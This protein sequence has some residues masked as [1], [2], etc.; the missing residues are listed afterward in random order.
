MLFY[1]ENTK[2]AA[3]SVLDHKGD[4]G[5]WTTS[6][7]ALQSRGGY[8]SPPNSSWFLQTPE[9]LQR[10]FIGQEHGG[11][12]GKPSDGVDRRSAEEN[13][14]GRI[15]KPLKLLKRNSLRDAMKKQLLF[16]IGVNQKHYNFFEV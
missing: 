7:D 3:T 10:Q 15:K 4:C 1:V 11:A 9:E 13:L 12:H 6:H 8:N 5:T 2:V 16:W 14:H